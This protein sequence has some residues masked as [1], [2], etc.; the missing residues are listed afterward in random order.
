MSGTQALVRLPMV[1]MWRDR[2][3]GLKTGTYI[4][5]YRGS[6]IGGYDMQLARAK[7]H[8]EPLDIVFQPGVN[9]ELAATAIWGTQQLSLSP[10][11][12]KDGVL[13]IWYGKGPGVDRSGDVFK[14][15]NAAGTSPRG[16]VLCI[17]G[18]DHACK[19]STIP[20]Q[21]DHAFAAALMPMV[22]PSNVHEFVEMGLFAIAMSRY[23]G[24]WTG[25]KCIADTIE[26]S[27]GVD[28]TGEGRQFV[29]P[30]DFEMPPDGVHWRWPDVPMNADQR[31]MEHK[32]YAALA[33]ARANGIDVH[34]WKAQTPRYGIVAS[35]KAYEDTMQ[36]L[37]ELELG[38][39]A[40]ERLGLSIYKVRMPWPL[41]PEGI[42]HFAEGLNEVMIVEERRE[43]IENQIKQ[44][45]FNW[46]A[47]VRPRI[48]GKFDDRD[49]PCLPFSEPLSAITVARAL[50]TR[51]LMRESLDD[52]MRAH[53][54]SRLAVLDARAR[55]SNELAPPVLR[56]PYFCSG[57]PHNTST[58]LPEGSRATAGIGCHY[59]ALWMDRSTE[60]FTQMGGEG[61]SWLSQAHFTDEAHHFA[62]LGDGTYFHSGMLA[63]RAAVASK[64]N[65]TYKILYNDAVAMTGGQPVDGPLT[66][67]AVAQNVRAEGVAR[68]ALVSDTPE[69]FDRGDFPEGT[70]FHPRDALDAVQ[71]ELRGVAGVSVL[72]YAQSCATEKR[73]QRKRGTLA[74]PKRFPVINARVCEG[75]GDCSVASNCLSVEPIATP[76]GAKRRVNLSNCNK[77]FSCLDGFCPSFVT[78]EGGKRRPPNPKATDSAPHGKPLPL[79]DLPTLERPYNL[80]VTGVGG[81]GVVTV[82]AV[83]A[84]AAHLEG[85]G[86]S[87]LDFTGFAQKF[88]PVLSYLRFAARP[89]D[90]HQV[91][92]DAGSADA[93]IGCDT[94]VSASPKAVA[95]LAK[96]TRAVLNL[97]QMPT[98]DVV[99][100]RDADL[101]IDARKQAV[102]GVIGAD[103]MMCVDANRLAEKLLG[104]TVFANV[105]LLGMAW[106]RGDVP[107]GLSAIEDAITL[108]GVAIRRN[109]EAF[110]WGRRLAAYPED[111]ALLLADAPE[112]V[113]DY[114]AELTRYQDAAYGR[115][116]R[117]F[118]DGARRRIPQDEAL[119]AAIAA[120][121]FRL[122]AYKDEYEVAR[123]HTEPAFLEQLEKTFEG[124]RPVF[125]LAPPFLPARR[126]WR[127]RPRKRAFGAWILPFLRGL[128]RLR[129]LR[130]RWCDPF[131]HMA[132]R[133]QDVALIAWY[134]GVMN[135]A[136]E[137][138]TE[139]NAAAV[140]ALARLAMDIRGYGPVRAQSAMQARAEA[141]ALLAQIRAGSARR[142]E[143]A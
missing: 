112:E 129:G 7:A 102:A 13:G 40:C 107:V 130:G 135:E 43:M 26:T 63:V 58:R 88:G 70:T 57:C 126:D 34:T 37:T 89:D 131:R 20:H 19:S 109:K 66:P 24:C 91:R 72:I 125:H 47:D 103:A 31:L 111:A 18:D 53:L 97:A 3:A 118:M 93:L 101:A 104:D 128:A 54:D 119:H 9:E 2:A 133:K 61:A 5:G 138:M 55:A 27:A 143:V 15:G 127:G 122:M 73:R 75:C 100:N 50:A 52:G 36:A 116:F 81:T 32:G 120:G 96:G 110:A 67:H 121:L 23:S 4:S 94:V 117:D 106:Q 105:L 132:E 124:A 99:L 87:V 114:E 85:K 140:L 11:A 44:Q 139:E 92:I 83:L 76:Y 56:T 78:M 1:Q 134:K 49:Q 69:A 142:S 113:P 136:L 17:A 28:L 65:I 80:L 77:D 33:F 16:G 59:M 86:A 71:R 45:L 30:T 35:G 48:V 123:L 29:T 6:P 41:E 12:R 90:L 42:R 39:D 64:V 25:M 137:A 115:A 21:S 108:N 74:D 51:L 38:R 10:G 141:D 98:G 46:R 84:M 8:L 82:G 95:A 14:H 62:N 79:P 68:I 60:G 22:Y